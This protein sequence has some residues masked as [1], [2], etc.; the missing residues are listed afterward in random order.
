ARTF[1]VH[2]FD[3]VARHSGDRTM[4]AGLEHHGIAALEERVHQRVDVLLE[5][6]LSTGNFDQPAL[7]TL[8]LRNHVVNRSLLAFIKGVGRIAPGATQ[9]ARRKTH[10]YARLTGSGGLTLDGIEDLV[11]RQH[12]SLSFILSRW[13]IFVSAP[14]AGTI[15]AV[16]ARGTASFIHR[17][18]GARRTSTN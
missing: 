12:G 10:E 11:D 1:H 5:Q 7:M 16:G 9:V 18:A 17:L 14:P 4:P 13:E 2:D 6:W 15:R 8:D 3:D